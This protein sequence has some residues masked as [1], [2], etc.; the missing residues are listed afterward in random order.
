MLWQEFGVNTSDQHLLKKDQAESG[1]VELELQCKAN[2]A[3]SNL[4]RAL[5]QTSPS[6]YFE[7]GGAKLLGHYTPTHSVTECELTL[8]RMNIGKSGS[9][10][11]RQSL[12]E[13]MGG[14]SLL[15]RL[16]WGR[17]HIL[18]WREIWMVYLCVYHRYLV[19]TSNFSQGSWIQKT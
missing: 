14:G 16:P 12:K 13:L 5:E 11:L 10:K 17:Q 4:V 1:R 7:G 3:S 6:R 8:E 15:T 18:L 9:L 19:T 2:K